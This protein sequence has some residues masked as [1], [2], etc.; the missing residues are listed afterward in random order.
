MREGGLGVCVYDESLGGLEE[1]VLPLRRKGEGRV[2][3]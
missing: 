3:F 1:D 2:Q